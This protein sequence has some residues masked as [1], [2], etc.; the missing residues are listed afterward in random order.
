M[1]DLMRLKE[2]FDA[3]G[4]PYVETDDGDGYRSIHTCSQEEQKAG[5]LESHFYR[6]DVFFEFEDGKLV[7]TP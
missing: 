1:T 6:Q 2:V 3:I 7:S 5:K 4:V